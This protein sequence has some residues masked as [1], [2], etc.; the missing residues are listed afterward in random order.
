ML[1]RWTANNLVLNIP[2]I[3]F[4]ELPPSPPYTPKIIIS[5]SIT[6]FLTRETGSREGR[7]PNRFG[8]SYCIPATSSCRKPNAPK[9]IMNA[10]SSK[11]TRRLFNNCSF[12]AP[13]LPSP[14]IIALASGSAP[15]PTHLLRSLRP[16]LAPP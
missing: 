8:K 5:S 1:H 4:L 13:R 3:G 9:R 2:R 11:L 10:H 15:S 6:P 12:S 16:N 14:E 7:I